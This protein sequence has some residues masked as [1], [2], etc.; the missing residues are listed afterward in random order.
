MA[1]GG[2]ATGMQ[3][4]R[5]HPSVAA[6]C[7][8]LLPVATPPNAIVYGSGRVPLIAMIRT[9]VVLNLGCGLLAWAGLLI[10]AR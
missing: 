4:A 8:F 7:A 1:L 2:V 6:S 10:F 5:L 3:N 9:G